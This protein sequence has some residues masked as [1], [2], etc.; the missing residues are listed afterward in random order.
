VKL[1]IQIPCFNEA[2]TLP[3]VLKDMPTQISGID[4]IEYQIIDDGSTDNT[5]EVAKQLGI[6]HIVRVRGKNRRWLGGHL[7]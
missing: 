5:I 4:V 1:I 7:N 2:S 6:H 3:L